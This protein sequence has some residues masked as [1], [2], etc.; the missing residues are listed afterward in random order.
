MDR[1]DRTPYGIFSPTFAH[2]NN[3][4]ILDFRKKSF[5]VITLS[6]HLREC[7]FLR[8]NGLFPFLC[9]LKV[10][11]DVLMGNTLNFICLCGLLFSTGDNLG[12]A[13]NA[14]NVVSLLEKLS[15]DKAIG[16]IYPPSVQ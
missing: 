7:T 5:C 3:I 15:M 9:G 13:F 14:N 6:M 2:S 11:L 8:P 16:R 1:N 4:N 10:C 12:K